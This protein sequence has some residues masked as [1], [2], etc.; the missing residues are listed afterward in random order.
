MLDF[1]ATGEAGG[2]SGVGGEVSGVV[3]LG[4]GEEW[5]DGAGLAGFVER[6]EEAVAAADL[7]LFGSDQGFGIDFDAS[8]DRGA[9]DVGDSGFELQAFAGIDGAEEDHGVDGGGGDPAAAGVAEGDDRATF[10]GHAEDDAAMKG[11]EEVGLAGVGDH[12]QAHAGG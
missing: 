6:D 9:A 11:A 10:V 2:L 4:F 8:F 7:A 3:G 5:G 12:G 1:V